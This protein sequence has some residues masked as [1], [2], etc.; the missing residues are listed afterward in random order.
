MEQRKNEPMTPLYQSHVLIGR[1]EK[2]IRRLR[3]YVKQQQTNAYRLYDWDIPEFPLRIEYFKPYWVVWI[4]M[5]HDPAAH[6]HIQDKAQNWYQSLITHFNIAPQHFIIKERQTSKGGESYQ[7]LHMQEPLWH[8]VHEK[9]L[10]FVLDLRSHVDVGLFLDHRHTRQ[11]V[12]SW[13][14]GK[15]VLNLFCYTASFSLYAA[16]AGAQRTVSVDLSPRTIQ[17]ALTNFKINGFS[18]VN[19]SGLT[20]YSLQNLAL[21]SSEEM[22]SFIQ[23]KQ[24]FSSKHLC[25]QQ[26][27]WQF[28][29][30]KP[31]EIFDVVIFDPPSFSKS[32]RA[33][34][35]LHT[36]NDQEQLFALLQPWLSSQAQLM[37][38]SN[39]KGFQPRFPSS[40]NAVELTPASLPPDIHQ[41]DIHRAFH[42][43][44]KSAQK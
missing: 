35:S 37:F 22:R 24:T 27:V 25:L 10:S 43:R 23:P 28:L 13:C 8:I 31:S 11:L 32:K 3:N 6:R 18:A 21:Q 14:E 40:W 30:G 5:P 41:L 7:Q 15:N 20:P 29:Q 44:T 17:W 4:F 26:D 38:S 34:R 39:Y 42:I 2:N 1:I 9:N 19:P 16:N 33:K 36:Q 12:S